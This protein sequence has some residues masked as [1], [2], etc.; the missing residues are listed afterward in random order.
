MMKFS[1]THYIALA[2]VAIVGGYL[3]WERFGAKA[4]SAVSAEAGEKKHTVYGSMSCGWT[5]KQLDHLKSKGKAYTFVDCTEGK[6][7]PEVDGFP[8]TRTPSGEIVVGF[9]P[10]L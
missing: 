7:P 2:V 10:D 4:M 6:C 3:L 8:T 5:R 9:N 1:R